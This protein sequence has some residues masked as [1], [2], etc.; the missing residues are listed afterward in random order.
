[1]HSSQFCAHCSADAKC[2][3]RDFNEQIWSVLLVWGEV[4]VKTVDKP[5]CEDCYNE[6]REVLI[7]RA[8]DIE[9]ALQNGSL[10]AAAAAASNDGKAK[11]KPRKVS[12]LAS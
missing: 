6:L 7:D 12:K 3:R 2:R 8:S 1:M 5:L 10:G 11:T 9:V 4:E